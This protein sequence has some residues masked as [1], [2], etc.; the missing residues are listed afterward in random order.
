MICHPSSITIPLKSPTH[1]C[2]FP[3]F[4]HLLLFCVLVGLPTWCCVKESACQWRRRRRLSFDPWVGRVPWSRKWQPIPVFL[5]R[6]FHGQK[7]LV[8]AVHEAAKSQTRSHDGAHSLIDLTDDSSRFNSSYVFCAC[9][10]LL[11]TNVSLACINSDYPTQQG[12][13][14]LKIHIIYL[15]PQYSFAQSFQGQAP[16]N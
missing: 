15:I 2:Y 1:F 9:P 3:V 10:R 4:Y 13:L 7:S 11:I 6:K 14:F 5:P 16:G 12:T 8:T